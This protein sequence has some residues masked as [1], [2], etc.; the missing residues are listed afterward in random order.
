M[1]LYLLPC[2]VDTVDVVVVV[3][4]GWHCEHALMGVVL[5]AVEVLL[6]QLPVPA[7]AL[8]DTRLGVAAGI[9]LWRLTDSFLARPVVP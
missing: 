8:L 6:R 9:V 1:V 5:E 2:P 4:M 3:V 7:G